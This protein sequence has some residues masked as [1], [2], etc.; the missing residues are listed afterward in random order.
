M[1][2]N[3]SDE[4]FSCY[5]CRGKKSYLDLG[6][7]IFKGS[8]ATQEYMVARKNGKRHSFEENT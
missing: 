2:A 4:L 1:K 5:S 8:E 7:N 6:G 3:L